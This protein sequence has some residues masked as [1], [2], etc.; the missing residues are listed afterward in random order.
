MRSLQPGVILGKQF[1]LEGP[2]G[3]GGM[4]IVWRARQL[5]LDRQVAIKT[6][7]H[8]FGTDQ[9]ARAR[10]ERE[11]LSASALHHPNAI[12]IYDFG[13]DDGV[14]FIAME[15]LRG[16]NLGELV[17]AMG[18]LP[19]SRMIAILTQ[20]ASVL[21]AA[22]AM[23]LIHRDLKLDNIFIEPEIG[24]GDRVVV[25]DFG[26]AYLEQRDHDARLTRQG[27]VVG[28]PL[29][30]APEAATGELSKPADLYALGI[31][32][33]ESLIGHP[34]FEGSMAQLMS[35]HAF[36][37]AIPV[38]EYRSDIPAE[39]DRLILEL[40]A[41]DPS[42][43][44]TAIELYERLVAMKPGASA[45]AKRR[46]GLDGRAARMISSIPGVDDAKTQ[47]D[48]SISVE[49]DDPR[50]QALRLAHAV[51]LDPETALSLHLNRVASLHVGVDALW[52]TETD[53]VWAP[54]VPTEELAA[55]PRPRAAPILTDV[56]T[57]DVARVAALLR[58]GVDDVITRPVSG[59]EL[60]RKAWRAWKK[61]RRRRERDR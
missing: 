45:R 24:G 43:R 13:E 39:V 37:L 23:G 14:V 40:L 5:R 33:Y 50:P 6:L 3:A 56:T 35:K 9:K 11:A 27:S 41:K 46:E 47:R 58:A 42:R 22:H 57:D 26:L 31:V 12:E 60:A 49:V 18:P 36:E 48:V 54:G 4:G 15:L 20:A 7:Q 34:P 29:Y 55:L 8:G 25:L 52:N 38:T 28:T 10:F 53:V 21:V 2:L 32:A 51:V 30:M 19:V 61:A 59:E 1:L 44:P 17:R 16:M